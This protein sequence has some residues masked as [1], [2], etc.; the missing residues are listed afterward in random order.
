[1]EVLVE[2]RRI[3]R[4]ADSGVVSPRFELREVHHPGSTEKRHLR[5]LP[6]IDGFHQGA[7]V[8]V[9]PEHAYLGGSRL[10]GG[11]R[12]HRR[13]RNAEVDIEVGEGFLVVPAP[14]LR[15]RTTQL[16]QERGQGGKQPPALDALERELGAAEDR[17][18]DRVDPHEERQLLLE[19]VVERVGV[20]GIVQP[21]EHDE[22][23]RT[24]L[25]VL[26]LRQVEVSV[27][28]V[29]VL[30]G[31]RGVPRA[32]WRLVPA[33]NAYRAFSASDVLV[34]YGAHVT[35]IAVIARRAE[36]AR[37]RI[38]AAPR[39]FLRA[40]AKTVPRKQRARRARI[41]LVGVRVRHERF[42]RVEGRHAQ[43]GGARADL[44]VGERRA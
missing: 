33:R 15:E 5:E 42:R 26:F 29:Q 1:M 32:Q 2:R 41:R 35:R 21:V 9:M 19:H 44:L 13:P 31:R 17:V 24:Q 39:G 27:D 43:I 4:A 40:R 10:A 28:A 20:V 14:R 22:A 36:G 38:V 25:V 30:R 16:L 23:V 8:T 34:R 11:R 3:G 7:H 6:L 12:H 18:E 37:H